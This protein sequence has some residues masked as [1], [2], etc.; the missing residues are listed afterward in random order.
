MQYEI[1]KVLNDV[2][3]YAY[4]DD[5]KL[6][7]YQRFCINF[8]KKESKSYHGRYMP[9]TKT[10]E[11]C[12]FTRGSQKLVIVA[13]HELAHHIDYCQRGI[14]DHQKSFYS[15]YR[16]LI[17]TALNMGVI[18]KKDI[19]NIEDSSDQKKLKGFLDDYRYESIQYRTD[20]LI[21]RCTNCFEQR[22]TLKS[23]GFHYQPQMQSW[24][25]EVDKSEVMSTSRFVESLNSTIKIQVLQANQ[26][27]LDLKGEI[28]LSGNTYSFK[29]N[30]KNLGYQFKD[31]H[32]R[33]R[34]MVS[35]YEREK[36][37]V[38]EISETIHSKVLYK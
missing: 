27:D 16:R 32:W 28:V 26:I 1:K 33:K 5:A 30:L 22:L 2:C 12:N 34:I 18:D 36:T 6:Q 3:Y 10:I 21:I 7:N 4:T 20:K 35:N 11:I 37:A 31:K 19:L 8:S 25:K 24:E 38:S 29:E 9:Y 15:V 13:L 23:I 14:T 17:H